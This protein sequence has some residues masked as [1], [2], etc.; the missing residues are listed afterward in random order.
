MNHIKEIA[1]K[2]TKMNIDPKYTLEEF[3]SYINSNAAT[4]ADSYLELEKE[5]T[6]R[7]DAEIPVYK[8]EI[9]ELKE[10]NKDLR[11]KIIEQENYCVKYQKEIVELEEYKK[12]Y[13]SIAGK[14]NLK[15]LVESKKQLKEENEK[16]KTRNKYFSH[17]INSTYGFKTNSLNPRVDKISFFAP[18][19]G[20]YEVDLRLGNAVLKLLQKDG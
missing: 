3:R 9:A 1:E 15:H 16:L 4:L 13:Q 20:T 14:A 8:E 6:F 5:L 17:I 10:E 7:K 19:V 18:F 11:E 2:I 12:M